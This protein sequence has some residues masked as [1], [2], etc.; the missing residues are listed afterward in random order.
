MS[1]SNSNTDPINENRLQKKS[2]NKFN[3][4]NN[5]FFLSKNSSPYWIKIFI[6]T[7]IGI[8]LLILGNALNDPNAIFHDHA[9]GMTWREPNQNY[10]KVKHLLSQ[11][12]K[13]ILI[14]GSSRVQT[15]PFSKME[16]FK[17]PNTFY[18]MGTYGRTLWNTWHDL[19]ILEK[20]NRLPETI[21]LGLDEAT[22]VSNDN[23]RQQLKVSIAYPDGFLEWLNFIK[24]YLLTKNQSSYEFLEKI[25]YPK[26][27]K[28]HFFDLDQTGEIFYQQLEPV[29]NS[30]IE[31]WKMNDVFNINYLQRTGAASVENIDYLKQIVQLCQKY[32]IRLIIFF[33]PVYKKFFLQADYEKLFDFK[34]QIS[35]IAN[36][37][38]FQAIESTASDKTFWYDQDHYRPNLGSIII[39]EIFETKNP[40]ELK[41]SVYVTPANIDQHFE[42]QKKYIQTHISN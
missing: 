35:Q 25:F 41:Y 9:N 27:N 32:Q 26:M 34:K 15:I 20:H 33:N 18:N 19:Q 31:H 37:Y 10:L 2:P 1:I 5:H 29:I 30:N 24:V 21:L 38:D 16:S 17:E 28:P 12:P 14:F 22:Y 4:L 39:K 42:N 11:H 7:S 8:L 6:I 13:K 23:S 36:F 3:I 40:S